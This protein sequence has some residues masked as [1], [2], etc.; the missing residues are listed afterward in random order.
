M[1]IGK[2][3]KPKWLQVQQLTNKIPQKKELRCLKLLYLV[4]YYI[5][6]F[7]ENKNKYYVN[8]YSFL[9]SVKSN[10]NIQGKVVLDVITPSS[11][12]FCWL[13]AGPGAILASTIFQSTLVALS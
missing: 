11:E 2:L 6:L 4:C 1:K 5:L 3:L 13:V 9:F 12:L 7:T 10:D 8:E